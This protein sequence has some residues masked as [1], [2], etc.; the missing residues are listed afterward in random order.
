LWEHAQPGGVSLPRKQQFLG[1]KT[2]LRQYHS[3]AILC[4][5]WHRFAKKLVT[6]RSRE[7]GFFEGKALTI[8]MI[9]LI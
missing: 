1:L 2:R 7:N 4:S 9:S 6:Q 5:I 8:S 3:T